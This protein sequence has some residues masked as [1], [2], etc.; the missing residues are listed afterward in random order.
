MRELVAQALCLPRRD[1][2]RRTARHECRAGRLR[3]CATGFTLLEMV[4]ATALMSIAV[5]GLLSLLTTVLANASRVKQYDQVA[6]LART[7][8]ND[9]LVISPLTLGQPLGG[10]FDEASGWKA[11]AVPFERSPDA[12]PG[13][14]QLIRID[15][16]VWWVD[17]G[18]R[19]S[20]QLE[21]FRRELIPMEVRR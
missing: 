11:V 9:L 7:K 20:V 15:L 17:R 4:V 21:G 14:F 3:A 12:M 6:M 2:S 18:E 10:Q 8:M 5:V 16:E 19:K 13:S 1:S